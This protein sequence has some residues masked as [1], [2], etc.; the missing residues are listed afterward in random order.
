MSFKS[1]VNVSWLLMRRIYQCWLLLHRDLREWS[2]MSATSSVA[3]RA[4][5]VVRHHTA[6]L[7]QA[8][9]RSGALALD[10]TLTGTTELKAGPDQGTGQYLTGPKRTQGITLSLTLMRDHGLIG[11]S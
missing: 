8:L 7:S 6:A 11:W 9:P 2:R 1:V 3:H 5:A 4:G 10:M